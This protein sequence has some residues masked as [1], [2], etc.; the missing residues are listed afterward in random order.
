[1]GV[2]WEL[3]KGGPLPLLHGE[4]QG[5]H[6]QWVMMN[7]WE[8]FCPL[9]QFHFPTC[10][11]VSPRGSR[12][13]RVLPE[14]GALGYRTGLTEPA[15]ALVLAGGHSLAA[16]LSPSLG[17]TYAPK[18]RY[19]HSPV[20]RACCSFSKATSWARVSSWLLSSSNI[21][22]LTTSRMK[23]EGSGD[24][25]KHVRK[26]VRIRVWQGLGRADPI[27]CQPQADEGK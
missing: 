17:H 1:M 16:G 9:G 19:L 27:G 14:P 24:E 18:G 5:S 7:S 25:N 10:Q 26:A 15:G 22:G 11:G 4:F 6:F 3:I 12:L 21:F 20:C 23:S 2:S 8:R 13:S